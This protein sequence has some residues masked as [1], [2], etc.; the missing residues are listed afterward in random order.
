MSA[1]TIVPSG[2]ENRTAKAAD[3]ARRH[4]EIQKEMID[5][6]RSDEELMKNGWQGSPYSYLQ[7][8]L[9]KWASKQLLP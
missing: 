5:F 3:L 6:M 9:A 4:D 8:T 1:K 2:I 7:F